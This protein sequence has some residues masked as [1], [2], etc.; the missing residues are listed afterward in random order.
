MFLIVI[1]DLIKY[2][3]KSWCCVQLISCKL[4]RCDIMQF[5]M[6]NLIQLDFETF[7]Y[8]HILPL[9]TFCGKLLQSAMNEKQ[10]ASDLKNNNCKV[11]QPN[12]WVSLCLLQLCSPWN[13]IQIMYLKIFPHASSCNIALPLKYITDIWESLLWLQLCN[14]WNFIQIIQFQISPTLASSLKL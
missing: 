3:L 13:F 4:M 14:M 2:L 10:E 12:I 9:L 6:I 1:Y 8:W 7:N 5:D 11:F